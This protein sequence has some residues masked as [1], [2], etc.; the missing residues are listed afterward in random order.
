MLQQT[1]VETV[2]PYFERFLE[3]FPD[4]EA[5]AEAGEEDV[6]AAWS[7]LGYYR[8]ARALR[9]AA[10]V[11]CRD[12][13]GEFPRERRGMLAL[14]G[15]G[16]Y[17]AGAVLSIAFGLPEPLVDGNVARVLARWFALEHPIGSTA[18]R[19]ELDRL[20]SRLVPGE[21]DP[22]DPGA[23]NQALM[24]LGALVCTPRHPDCG[25]CPM[26]GCCRAHRNGRSDELPRPAARKKPTEVRLELL[27]VEREEQVLLVRRPE[28]GRMASMWELPTC[29]TEHPE[30]GWSGL[31]PSDHAD[32]A[33]E[34]D[35]GEP[36][37]SLSHGI[38]R[39]RIRATVR[40]ASWNG[41]PPRGRWRWFGLGGGEELA[42]TGLTRKALA[43]FSREV[44]AP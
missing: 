38:T 43:R 15:V 9:E 20:T 1:R 23:W 42:L 19:R 7:G 27:W 44:A 21:E 35:G 41:A 29:E 25:A 24:E 2:I 39:Y 22:G 37:G 5:L 28:K 34:V 12:R 31:W 13:G 4:L 10:I 8:R 30:H 32:P 26:A 18:L 33:L 11:L 17:T 16:P 40:S 14:P 36:L 6:V 3:R